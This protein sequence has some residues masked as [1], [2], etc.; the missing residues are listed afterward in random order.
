MLLCEESPELSQSSL[1]GQW[2]SHLVTNLHGH[3]ESSHQLSEKNGQNS[4]HRKTFL[5]ASKK[6]ISIKHSID[7]SSVG[8]YMDSFKLCSEKK[9]DLLVS[10]DLQ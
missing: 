2:F 7:Q 3:I 4:F 9:I 8:Q 10:H 1:S 5:V 6:V